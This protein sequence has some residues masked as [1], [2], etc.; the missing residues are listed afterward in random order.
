MTTLPDGFRSF[1]PYDVRN[2]LEYI[3][4]K[5]R[6]CDHHPSWHFLPARNP[7]RCS[8]DGCTCA[9]LS[10]E[11]LDAY[12]EQWSAVKRPGSRPAIPQ[13]VIRAVIA[14][15]G[16]VCRYCSRRV[17]KRRRGP[18]RLHLDHVVP[19]SEG[20]KATPDNIV[21]A[22]ARCNLSKG[23]RDAPLSWTGGTVP[24]QDHESPMSHDLDVSC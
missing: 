6:A 24:R 19:F 16:M 23:N 7:W 12:V 17:H 1:L 4:N 14:R 3:F 5:C 10:H 11:I 9:G 15:D 22:C 2:A 8:A 20:G 21:V 18:G 13:W